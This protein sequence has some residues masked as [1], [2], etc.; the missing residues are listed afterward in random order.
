MCVYIYIYVYVFFNRVKVWAQTIGG[1]VSGIPS[2]KGSGFQ[3]PASSSPHLEN[4]LANKSTSC[5]H[6]GNFE[7]TPC[8]GKG[9]ETGKDPILTLHSS[10]AVRGTSL[11][12]H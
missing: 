1:W 11:P 8:I 4:P 5:N 2:I 6:Q 7:D 3:V 10:S 12:L 9:I